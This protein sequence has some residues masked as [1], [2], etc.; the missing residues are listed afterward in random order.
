[1]IVRVDARFFIDSGSCS[2]SFARSSKTPLVDFL[3]R[4]L[5]SGLLSRGRKR[6]LETDF[7]TLEAASGAECFVVH[8]P[9]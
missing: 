4:E 2:P 7:S 9:G 1:M 8:V 3:A 5:E 6:R